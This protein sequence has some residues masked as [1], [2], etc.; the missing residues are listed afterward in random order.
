MLRRYSRFASAGSGTARGFL[1][2]AGSLR[3]TFRRERVEFPADLLFLSK[4]FLE[5]SDDLPH[6]HR[7]SPGNKAAVRN[8]FV[9]IDL[10]CHA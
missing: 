9:T 3:I 10:P 7:F 2:L 1:T 4:R 5:N 6:F 8:Y